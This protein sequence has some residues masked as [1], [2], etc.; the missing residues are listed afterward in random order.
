[1]VE[2]L[3]VHRLRRELSSNPKRLISL[4]SLAGILEIDSQTL[5]NWGIGGPELTAEEQLRIRGIN[6]LMDV[7]GEMIARHSRV[8]FLKLDHPMLNNRRPLDLLGTEE[9]QKQVV[10]LIEAAS[11]GSFV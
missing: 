8:Q 5:S 2:I 3:E 10:D 9:G 4:N 7:M 11:T 1:M 6:R